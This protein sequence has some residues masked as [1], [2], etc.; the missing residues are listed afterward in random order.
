MPSPPADTQIPITRE[1]RD[2]LRALKN[3]GERY[4]DVIRRLMEEADASVGHT[5]DAG[6]DSIQ[7]GE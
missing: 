2:Q 7:Q 6:N 5:S 4:D 3:G 1:T